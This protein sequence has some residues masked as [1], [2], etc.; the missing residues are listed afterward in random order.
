MDIIDLIPAARALLGWSQSELG[1]NAHIGVAALANI[2]NK[3]QT[4][5]PQTL[6]KIKTAL[7]SEGIEFLR[8]GV[9]KREDGIRTITGPN[10]YIELLEDVEKTLKNLS[11]KQLLIWCSD[12]SVSPPEVN[13]IY[14]RLRNSGIRMRQLVEEGNSYLMGDLAEY[15]FIPKEY[16]IN[17]VKLNYGNKFAIVNGNESRVIIHKDTQ[18]SKSHRAIFELLWS[19]LKQPQLSEAHEIF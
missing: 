14:R 7:E 17:V 19:V 2:E 10:C 8:N 16:F 6:Y 13:E 1:A 12:D 5:R 15:R 18:A 3:K 11:D 9:I 4:P